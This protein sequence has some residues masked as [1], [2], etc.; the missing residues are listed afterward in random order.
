MCRSIRVQGI[1]VIEFGPS[2]DSLNDDALE[3]AGGLLLTEAVHAQP[4]RLVLDLSQTS[5]IGSTF[6]ELLVRAWKRL[7][8]RGGTMV[9]CGLHPFCTEVLEVTRLTTLWDI[10]ATR[11]EAVQALAS[12]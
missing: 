5:F 6:I 4:P 7:R 8:E 9:F 3:E 2:Y 1:V 12:Q 11:D 10:Y